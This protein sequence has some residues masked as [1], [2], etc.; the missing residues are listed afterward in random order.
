[1]AKTKSA[2]F[3]QSCGFEAPKWLGKCP[4]CAQWNTFV[5]EIVEKPNAAAPNWK[6]IS[7]GSTSLQRA[8][9]PVQ[10]SD[11]TF[12]EE[13]RILTPD[14][15]LNRVLGGGI[16]PGSL[17]LIGGEP[18]IGKSTLMLQ[19]AM[20]MPAAKILYVSG[21]ESDRQIKM[22]AERISTVESSKL[23]VQSQHPEIKTGCFVLTETS[24]Q[25][26]FKQIE[27]LQPDLVI[28]DSIQTLHSAHIE[29]TPG[30][31][32]QVRECTAELLRFAK[33][34]STPVFLIGH[35]T[36]DG[37]IAGP[38]ILEHMVDTVLQFEGDRHHVYRILRAIK[39]R[40]G[41]ASELGIYEMLGAGLR[42][43]SN[44]SEILLS[45]RDEALSGITISATLEGL[46]PM[47]I[48]TQALVS[49]SAYGTPQRSATGFDTRR[50]NMLLAV[51]EK[52]CGF[53]LG[54]QD[55]FLNITGGIRVEDP[56]IDLGLAAAIISSHEDMPIS[57]KTCFA[58]ELGLSGEIR[59]VNRIEQRIAEAQKLGFEQIFISKYNLPGKKDKNQLDLSH[60]KIEIKAVSRIEE[61]F[62]L[63]FG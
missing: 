36:K 46:R 31:V 15:E 38:K 52:R 40:F 32:S 10:V 43:V 11:I 6:S 24:T 25:N 59:A 54:N 2:Y 62:G 56:A 42:E 23:N 44:P 30:S 51:L 27:E 26:I 3:C 47:L 1:M 12:S 37:M 16:V 22:R 55:V 19:I 39:N 20:S 53:R 34:S 49:T 7:N 28:V 50:M 29:S 63:L 17:V 60:Y 18:G 57:S 9:K 41:S 4:S 21:E 58:G 14:K 45:Q 13:H 8:N 61:V 48:E 33:E 35:I 5:E